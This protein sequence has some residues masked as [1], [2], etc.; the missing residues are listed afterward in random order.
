MR[1]GR[2]RRAIDPAPLTLVLDL[3]GAVAD[4]AL[5]PPALIR[6]VHAVRIEE[7]DGVAE[8]ALARAPALTRRQVEL[9]ARRG[10][11]R[12]VDCVEDQRLA[13]T[14]LA[15]DRQH[16]AEHL[17]RRVLVPMPVDE[18]DAAD[19][20]AARRPFSLSAHEASS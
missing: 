14:V 1:R 6:P 4:R 16:V 7:E 11:E 10:E 17:K 5:A 8:R 18:P 15:D 2:R 12:P 3:D 9:L 13:G 19:P 20:S